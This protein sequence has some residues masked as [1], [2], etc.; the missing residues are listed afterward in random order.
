MTESGRKKEGHKDRERVRVRERENKIDRKWE[1]ER[2]RS[3][4]RA[5]KTKRE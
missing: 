5:K 2:L 3:C 4:V 1:T